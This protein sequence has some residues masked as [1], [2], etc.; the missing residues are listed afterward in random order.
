MPKLL[1]IEPGQQYGRLTVVELARSA[2]NG[3]WWRCQCECGTMTEVTGT[4]LASGHTRSC[5]CLRAETAKGLGKGQDR[6]SIRHPLYGTW[7]SMKARC[8]NPN[9]KD[10]PHYGGRGIEVC[11]RWNQDFW[12]FVKD[13]GERPEGKTLERIDN[14]GPYSPENCTWATAEEQMANRRT[15]RQLQERINQLEAELARFRNQGEQ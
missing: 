7:A 3:K 11:D 5:G 8:N 14:D 10:Y 13:M 12:A 6:G 4:R 2:P 9:I 1:H 15:V